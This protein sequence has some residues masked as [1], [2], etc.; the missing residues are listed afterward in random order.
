M[1]TTTQ[2]LANANAVLTGPVKPI[3]PPKPGK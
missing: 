1:T 2:D 3:R